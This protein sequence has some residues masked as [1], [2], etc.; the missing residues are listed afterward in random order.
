M[1]REFKLSDAASIKEA[2]AFYYSYGL[3]ICHYVRE[4]P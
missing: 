1:L 4:D 3:Q 2:N